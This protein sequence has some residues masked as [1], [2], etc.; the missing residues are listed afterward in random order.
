MDQESVAPS[1]P[2]SSPR[3]SGGRLIILFIAAIAAVALGVFSYRYVA[4]EL[5]VRRAEADL[6]AA[7][8]EVDAAEPHGWRWPELE[9][10]REK[11][12]GDK[13]GSQLV[14][15][16]ARLLP[17]D[18]KDEPIFDDVRGLPPPAQ[19]TEQQ[20]ETLRAVL[21]P[22][23]PALNKARK[24]VDY[25]KGRFAPVELACDFF[26]TPLPHRH[27]VYDV[28]AMLYCDALLACQD[29]E[30]AR[31]CA[32][33]V[34]TLNTGRSI[35]DEPIQLSQLTR[36]GVQ[37]L[38]V[39]ALQRILAHATKLDSDA[40]KQA[41]TLLTDEID[42]N[43]SLTATRGERA[44]QHAFYA[45]L[46]PA[47]FLL[48]KGG[49]DPRWD[50]L[51]EA[52]KKVEAARSQ[53]FAM[54]SIT[55]AI[56][57]AKMPDLERYVALEDWQSALA[58]DRNSETM[59]YL[60]ALFTSALRIAGHEQRSDARM[61]CAVTGLAAEQFRVEK[62]RWPKDLHELV[63]ARLLP[64][65]PVDRYDGKTLR[66]RHTHDGIVLY[67]VDRGKGSDGKSW[68]NLATPPPDLPPV[69]FRLWNPDRRRQPPVPARI[70]DET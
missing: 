10:Q 51:G 39:E 15:E 31:A 22:L 60:A 2:Q 30:Y 66:L 40:L 13:N 16:A 24:L 69:E 37:G 21:R 29:G 32:C 4:S 25:P 44:G 70:H 42:Q 7:L 19:L 55:K 54:R 23:E 36:I 61:E 65:L 58:T 56:E 68:D 9:A 43:L 12:P 1:S 6:Q 67:S 52:A 47:E 62:G 3:G 14:V 59:P 41:R 46:V 5:A 38:A 48:T 33:A 8:A 45:N 35:G 28:A 34:A 11:I 18:W 26:S 20:A 64:K 53:A 17:K 27:Q 50:S 49:I 63:A 57:C